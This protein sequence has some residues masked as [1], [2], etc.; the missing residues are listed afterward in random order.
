MI[1][2]NRANSRLNEVPTIARVCRSRSVWC[3]S[4]WRIGRESEMSAR[5]AAARA[6]SSD[7]R[8]IRPAPAAS[9]FNGGRAM[10][11]AEAGRTRVGIG[12]V[13]RGPN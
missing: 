6:F 8:R 2:S 7:M 5:V 1:Y 12:Q 4:P 13:P 11:H 9:M 3:S 10:T